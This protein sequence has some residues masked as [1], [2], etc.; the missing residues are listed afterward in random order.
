MKMLVLGLAA[1]SKD[2]LEDWG[3]FIDHL[4]QLQK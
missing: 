2:C 4:C 3:R 1:Q